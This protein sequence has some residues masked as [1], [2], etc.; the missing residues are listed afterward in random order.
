[1]VPCFALHEVFVFIR[2][3]IL[4]PSLHAWSL[5]HNSSLLVVFVSLL[6]YH[7]LGPSLNS[8]LWFFFFHDFML[9]SRHYSLRYRLL[10]TFSLLYSLYYIRPHPPCSLFVFCPTLTH[11]ATKYRFSLYRLAPVVP[12]R[13]RDRP[14]FITQ[15][16]KVW[17]RHWL[18]WW[19]EQNVMDFHLHS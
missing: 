14:V 11:I 8:L 15:R 6:L 18:F 17:A 10:R 16:P 19:R 5:F 2:R 7:L 12:V 1:M 9:M 4:T 3:D 13:C